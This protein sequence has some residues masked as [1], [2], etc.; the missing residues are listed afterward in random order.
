MTLT[1]RRLRRARL[2]LATGTAIILAA[3]AAFAGG[4]FGSANAANFEKAEAFI[5]W[6]VLSRDCGNIAVTSVPFSDLP[7][8]RQN[9]YACQRQR[10]DVVVDF[11]RQGWAVEAFCQPK[12]GAE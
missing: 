4:G 10:A 5:L 1:P 11:G 2:A 6:V 9:E 7:T 8:A 12:R 3:T